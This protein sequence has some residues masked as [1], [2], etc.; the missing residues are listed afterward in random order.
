M[1][2]AI[3][4]LLESLVSD[5]GGNYVFALDLL[6]QYRRDRE[7]VDATWREYFDRLSGRANDAVEGSRAPAPES[8]PAA[9]G[10]ITVVPAAAPA[11]RSKALVVPAIL[12]GDIA[13]PIRGGAVRIVENMEASLTIPTAT[14]V[15]TVPVRT[16]EENRRLLNKHRDATGGSKISFTHVIAWAILRALDAFPRLNDAYAELEGQP[17]RIQ[18]DS[19]RLGLAVDVQKKDG[20]RTLLVPNL[21]DAQKLDFA[22]FLKAYDELVSRARKGAVTPDDFM[23]TTVSLTNPGTVGTTS[24]APRLMPGQGV[25]I[26]TGALDYPAEYRSMASRTLSL[27]GISKVMTLTSTYDHR[28][29]QGA[30]SGM[31]LARMEDLLKGDDGFYE[32]I[33]EDLKVPHRPVRWEIDVAPGIGGP[34]G[35]REEIEKQ[36]RVLQLIHNYRVRGHLVSDLDPLDSKRAPHKDLDPAT[37]GLTMWDLDREF[38]TNGLS[39]RDRAT[40]REIIE[41]LRDTYCGTLGIEYMYIADPERKEW[42]Q[43]RME[44]ARNRLP[45]TAAERKRILEKLLEAESFERFLHARF[46][47]H[48]RFSLEGCEALIPLLDRILN[49]AARGGVKEAVI[50]MAH[51][52]RLNVLANTVKKSLAQIFSEFEGNVDPDSIQGSGDVKYHLGATGEHRAPTGETLAVSVAPNPS[53]LEFVNPVVE[54]MVRAK[55]DAMGDASRE[56]VLPILLHGDAAVAGQ[57]IVAETLNLAGLE[58]YWTGG[59][60]HVVV[61]NQIGFTTLPQDAR[62]STYCTDVAK[63]VHAPVFHVNGDDPEAVAWAAALALEYRQ[64]FK[65]DVMIDLVGYRRWGHNEGDEPSYTQPIMYAK[66][67]SHPSVATIYGEQGLRGGW[68]ARE[69][70]DA[71]WAEKKAAMQR[72]GE[73]GGLSVIARRPPTEPPAVDGAAMRAR[74]KAVLGALSTLPESFEIHPKLVPFVKARGELLEGRGAVDW[75]T[76]ESLA[77]GTLLLEGVPVRLSGQDVGRGTFSQRHAVLYDTRTAREY[78][79]LNSIAPAGTRFEVHDSLLSEAA[80]MG[81]EYGYAVAEHRALVMWE[82]QFGDFF[83]GAQVIVDQFFAASETKWGQPHGLV[84]LL[85]HGHEGQGPEHSSGRIERFLNLCAEDNMRVLYPSTPASFFHLL[86]WQGRAAV[87]KPMVVFTPKSLLRH[88][89][90]VASL[91]ELAEGRFRPVLDD[92][93]ATPAKVRRVVLTSGKLYYDLLKGQEDAGASHVALVRLEQLYPVP[94]AELVE[95]LARYP[96]GAELVWAQ[97]EPRNMGAWR[98]V[99]EQFLEGGFGDPGRRIPRYVGRDQSAAPAPGSHKIHLLEQEAIVREALAP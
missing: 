67:K 41:T 23:G 98:F 50:G 43:E 79:P 31:F 38:I 32:R 8:A 85:P 53:H 93:G 82:A 62:S 55:Q 65:K 21:K 69:E 7:S 68:V 4:P 26:A 96:A 18:R 95:A 86:R 81:F 76:A 94:G 66:I 80:V 71:L 10:E 78:V 19:V 6:E 72:G 5:F 45:L 35:G 20:S 47:G 99:R 34:A 73:G 88:P 60:I 29:I 49:D 48:K 39:G 16:L 3:D 63:M 28:I 30:E 25:I 75:A 17:H 74:L 22:A 92:R 9:K 64:R 12:P 37:Y 59:T 13:Q 51:R 44:Q 61:N 70:L 54:G 97:E 14:S 46:I 90:C 83:N 42:L 40:L 33:F 15:R 84:L 2:T 56:R 89:R 58:G 87:E 1:S 57:G 77:W 11:V 52:G 91:E 24:S 27:L 36:A